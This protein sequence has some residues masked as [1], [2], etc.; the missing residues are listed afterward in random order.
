MKSAVVREAATVAKLKVKKSNFVYGCGFGKTGSLFTKVLRETGR[1]EFWNPRQIQYFNS[2]NIRHIAAGFGFSV[3]ASERKLYG[4]G[5]DIFGNNLNN[6]NYWSEG[7]CLNANDRDEQFG[8]IIGVAAGRRHFLVASKKAVYAFGDNAHGQCG[9]DPESV[10]FVRLENKP[11]QKITISSDSEIAQVHCTLDT[12]FIVLNSGEVFS[13]GLGTDGQLGRGICSC[14]WRCLPIE[15]DLKGM[16]VASLKGSTDTLMAV[17]KS[18][19]LFMWG[20]NEYEQMYPFVKDIQSAFPREIRLSME[21]IALADST[22]TSCIALSGNDQV[23]VWGFGILG[24]GPNVTSLRRPA[25]LESNLFSSGPNDSGKVKK[26]FAGNSSMFAISRMDNLFSWGLNRFSHLG[27][28]HDKDQYFPFQVDVLKRPLDVSVGPDHVRRCPMSDTDES[29]EET[30]KDGDISNKKEDEQEVESAA[31]SSLEEEVSRNFKYETLCKYLDRMQQIHFK[32]KFGKE[33]ILKALMTKWKSEASKFT[34]EAVS[35]YPV[36]RIMANSLDRRKFR[37]KSKRVISK[38]CQVLFLPLKTKK[39]LL[40][41]DSKS[42][43]HSIMKLAEEV[44]M[45]NPTVTRHEL[46]LFDVNDSL[47]KITG[48]EISNEELEKLLKACSTVREVYWLLQVLIRKIERSLKVKSANLVSWIH[49]NG[50][51]LYQSGF[52]LREICDLAMEGKMTDNSSMLFRRFE[53]ML[54]ARIRHGTGDVYDKLVHFCGQEFYVELKYDGEHFLLHRGPNCE[55]RY[56]S[57]VQNDFTNTIAPMLDHRINPY[58]A[59]SVESCILDTELLLWDTIDERFVGH[60]AQASD[61]R[62]YDV[63]ALRTD[64]AVEPSVAV[65]D[66]L[67]LNGKPLM[68][69]PLSERLALLQN[70]NVLQKQ[71]KTKI[72]V[73]EFTIVKTREEF[74]SLYQEAVMNG[75][76]GIVAKKMDSIY[77]VGIRQ[78]TNGWF[79]IKPFHLGDETLDL[80]IV[81]V[82]L[83]RN[84]KI[85]NYCVATFRDGKFFMVGKV[86]TGLDDTTRSFIKN[87]LMRN[88]GFLKSDKIPSWIHKDYTSN[89]LPSHF[90][91]QDNMQVVEIRAKGLRN[92]RLYA[93]TLK[94]YRDDK[95]VKDIDQYQAFLDFDKNLRLD[96]IKNAQSARDWKKR[97]TTVHVLEQYQIKKARIDEI[98][99]DLKG[100][101]VCVLRGTSNVTIQDLQKI[102]V[103]F[104]GIHVANPGP[105]T[106][107]VVTGEPKHVKSKSIIKSNKYNVVSADWLIACKNVSK[108]IPITE[109]EAIHVVDDSLY[110]LFGDD[111]E[112][113]NSMIPS[114]HTVASVS[115]LLDKM[116]RKKPLVAEEALRKQ[117]FMD[118]KFDR[119]HGQTFYLHDDLTKIQKMY[120]QILLKMHGADLSTTQSS[121]ITHVVVPDRKIVYDNLPKKT[122][123]VDICWLENT[124]DMQ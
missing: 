89:D 110:S 94:T 66:I 111:R 107:F 117:L 60:N 39:E 16:K 55:M 51:A 124:L 56:Y 20:Q 104:G 2:R 46:S 69:V 4:G 30:V 1:K 34:S 92:G 41:I 13:F 28:S 61:G 53:P 73:S 96:S 47:C 102:I 59:P 120:I 64:G 7:I 115:T 29:D 38:V 62:I 15:G 21:K 81:G 8:T 44:S 71:D 5:V 72:F 26:I 65:F 58:F 109:K 57:R 52:S 98:N 100:K 3:L 87:R 118:E 90:V 17:T 80:A 22:A 40:Q 50:A 82:D 31:A 112:L 79:K 78:I 24:M 85:S 97:S 68:D 9:Q 122:T 91:V 95:Y 36:L 54:L 49:P 103:S 48:G 121:T 76:E 93:P 14:D 23:Y 43:D 77:K 119:F 12:S 86:G 6:S 105:K 116:K 114:A 37:M 27:L 32:N 63:K 88:H 33:R 113:G 25:L 75:Q 18:G 108:V 19:E 123:I 35:F 84:N 11:F 10:P 101:Q 67:F 106:L 99:Q 74:A 42:A 83:G 45:R 70:G